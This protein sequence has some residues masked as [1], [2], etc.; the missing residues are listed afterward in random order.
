MM[1]KLFEEAFAVSEVELASLRATDRSLDEA[2]QDFEELAELRA[3]AI[4][5]NDICTAEQAQTSLE[6]VK[7]EIERKL[8]S[9][10]SSNSISKTQ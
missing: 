6:E 4:N 2:C 7:L 8:M 1:N 10:D 5:D 9:A 3:R